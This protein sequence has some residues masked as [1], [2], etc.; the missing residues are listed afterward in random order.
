MLQSH[1]VS[2]PT[3]VRY[4]NYFI[5]LSQKHYAALTKKWLIDG[6]K[7]CNGTKCSKVCIFNLDTGKTIDIVESEGMMI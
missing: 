1:K 5:F 2:I 4:S 6:F 7:W 3:V